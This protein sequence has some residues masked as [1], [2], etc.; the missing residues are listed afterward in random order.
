MEKT[1]DKLT[2]ILVV[3]VCV[4][5]LMYAIYHVITTRDVNAIDGVSPPTV[6][7]VPAPQVGE[8]DC[9]QH[10]GD[11]AACVNAQTAGR[12]CSWYS[13]CRACIVG[14]HDGKTYEQICGGGRD[15]NKQ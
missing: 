11:F 13:D 15:R 7:T 10:D 4:T 5:F 3:L 1:E 8:Y 2:S 6:R 12:G 9:P 14:G